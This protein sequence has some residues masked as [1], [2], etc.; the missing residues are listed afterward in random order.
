MGMW[1]AFGM[2]GP[3]RPEMVSVQAEG[4]AH[5]VQAHLT[6][7]RFAEPWRDARTR[8]SGI[9]VPSAVSDFLMLDALR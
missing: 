4:C 8:T 1:K 9:R 7:E 5:I 6:G 3:E 2:I